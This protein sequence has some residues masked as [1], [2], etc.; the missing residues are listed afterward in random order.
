MKTLI[1][2]MFQRTICSQVINYINNF[3]LKLYLNF[4]KMWYYSIKII[5]ELKFNEL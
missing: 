5:T 3:S 1:S 2:V 4:H